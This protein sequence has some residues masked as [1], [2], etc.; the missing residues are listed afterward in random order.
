MTETTTTD[1]TTPADVIDITDEL[2]A[3]TAPDVA[4]E[5]EETPAEDEPRGNREAAKYR[6]QL[7][8]AEGE[9]DAALQALAQARDLAL[10]KILD[11]DIAI[12]ST[13]NNAPDRQ[14]RMENS[15]D[16]FEL[17]YA[18]RDECWN[19][20]GTLNTERI[21]EAVAK[22]Y[23]ERRRLFHSYMIV[24][25]EGNAPDMS[26]LSNIGDTFEAAFTPKDKRG[27]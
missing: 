10:G 6:K 16:L 7:R 22:M 11:L 9:R 21:R 14:V 3:T 23:T 8:E 12:P 18:T 19:T 26:K 27:R 4:P 15:S 1:N 2:E 20:D 5:A 13:R 17:G 25:G 24:R